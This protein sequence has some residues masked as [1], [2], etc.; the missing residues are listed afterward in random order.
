M[1][2]QS[3]AI[4]QVNRLIKIKD[5]YDRDDV[6]RQFQDKHIILQTGVPGYSYLPLVLEDSQ[7]KYL[8]R[9]KI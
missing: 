1:T 6:V 5:N 9:I 4:V 2:L 3:D 7:K 8:S